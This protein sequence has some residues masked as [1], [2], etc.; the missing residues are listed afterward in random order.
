MS[1]YRTLVKLYWQENNK[2]QAENIVPVPQV[3]HGLAW[4]RALACVVWDRRFK[5]LSSVTACNK[6]LW[7]VTSN[8]TVGQIF[9]NFYIG[10]F[11]P[12]LHVLTS[13]LEAR[14]VL[15]Y[16]HTETVYKRNTKS[17]I[18]S[19]A[20]LCTALCIFIVSSIVYWVMRN[21][22]NVCVSLPNNSGM[23]YYIT[24]FHAVLLIEPIYT[25]I[26]SYHLN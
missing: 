1:E 7:T 24:S 17:Q 21:L 4:I 9:W 18:I 5:G 23:A 12:G 6:R 22:I 11:Q 14:N 13:L 26:I 3:Q 2:V 20:T 16:V 10:G 8:Y 25:C 19:F 15:V